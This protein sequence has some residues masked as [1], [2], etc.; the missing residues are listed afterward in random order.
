MRITPSRTT[1]RHPAAIAA[2]VLALTLAA[3]PF[4]PDGNDPR[5]SITPS[6]EGARTPNRGVVTAEMRAEI[7]RVV[8][9]GA[10]LGRADGRTAAAQKAARCATFEGQRYCLGVGWT[11]RS[12]EEVAARLSERTR[13]GREQTGDLDGDALLARATSR[14]EAAR[15]RA[16][17]AELTAAAESVGKVWM[18]RH[19]IQG[20][21]LPDGFAETHPEIRIRAYGDNHPQRASIIKGSRSLSQNRT[22]W[23]GPAT[24]QAIGWGSSKERTDQAVWARRLRTT[25]AGTAITDIVRVVNNHTKYDRKNYAGTYIALD[26][27]D[28]TFRQWYRL[29]MRHIHDYRAPVVLH[30]VLLTQY[31]PYLDDDASGHFQV[32]RGYDQN[33]DGNRQIGYFEP[34]DQSRFDPSEPTIDRVQWRNAYK[35]YRANL[36]HFQQNVGV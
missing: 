9:A 33:P 12:P 5:G 32:G 28:F 22:Y 8:A 15:I 25:S 17:R 7:E 1:L 18:L 36:D 10:G 19:E 3:V 21:P 14:S 4:L 26:I 30:P 6:A 23:C 24:M 13:P 20:V 29:M 2:A 34:W 35:S 27:G 11:N 16:E 31:Y